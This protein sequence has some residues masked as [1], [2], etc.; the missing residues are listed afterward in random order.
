MDKMITLIEL[1]SKHAMGCR[2]KVVND[3]WVSVVNPDCWCVQKLD[4]VGLYFYTKSLLKCL[5]YLNN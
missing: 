5:F 3:I 4:S 1:V 2:Y